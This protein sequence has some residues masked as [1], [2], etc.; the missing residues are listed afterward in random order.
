MSYL[1]LA[2]LFSIVA[3]GIYGY[4]DLRRKPKSVTSL[5]WS[6]SMKNAK[7]TL[8]WV[9]SVSTDVVNQVVVV[10]ANGVEVFAT[11][12][13]PDVQSVEVGTFAEDTV[14][15]ATVT[16]AD[17]KGNTGVAEAPSFTVPDLEN[18]QPV[19]GLGWSMEVVDL[20]EPTPG[21]IDFAP[22]KGL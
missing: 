15:T 18:P 1:F 16:V 21:P 22:D 12:L 2:Y 11:N 20:E 4:Y 6:L 8:S 13:P 17:D 7:V 9:K 10:L 5:Y 3:I 19:T 14:L